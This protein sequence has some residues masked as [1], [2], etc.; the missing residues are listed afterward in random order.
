MQNNRALSKEL[1]LFL[2][3]STN[4]IMQ[5]TIYE[6]INS[7][8]VESA[9]KINDIGV[10]ESGEYFCSASDGIRLSSSPGMITLTVLTKDGRH[11]Y[12][13]QCVLTVKHVCVL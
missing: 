6:R 13:D 1:F 4:N 3:R 2:I 11:I 7:N 9:L 12:I 8:F 10:E 5:F